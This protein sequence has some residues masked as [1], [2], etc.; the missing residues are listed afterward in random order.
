MLG[1]SGAWSKCYWE[2]ASVRVPAF[3]RCPEWTAGGRLSAAPISCHD[4]T[5]TILDYAMGAAPAD[6]EAVR[7]WLPE[8]SSVSLRPLATGQRDRVRDAAYSENGGQFRPPWCMVDDG[9][10]KYVRPLDTGDELLYDKE[11]DPNCLQDVAGQVA[12]QIIERLRE[13]MLAV[14]LQ[15]PSPKRGRAAYSPLVPHA[16]TRER[17]E[18]YVSD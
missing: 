16:I 17:L 11:N 15:H 14:H 6:G 10:F 8:A 2:D 7:R 5:A 9:R 18:R 13:S 4:V 12:P 3:L 1:D